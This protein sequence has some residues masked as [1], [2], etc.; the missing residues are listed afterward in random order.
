MVGGALKVLI[1]L[2]V[3]TLP[4]PLVLKMQMERRQR[5]LVAFLLGLGYLVTAAGAVRVYYTWKAFYDTND[6]TWFQYPAFIA[7]SLE[8]NIAVVR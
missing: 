8:N 5:Y 6:P 7:A 2:L 4:I 3:T 1:D